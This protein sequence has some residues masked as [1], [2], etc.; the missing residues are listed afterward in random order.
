MG[1]SEITLS[2]DIIGSDE[3]HIAPGDTVDLGARGVLVWL[4]D[5]DAQ[6]YR[7]SHR[8]RAREIRETV[9]FVEKRVR[10]E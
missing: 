8:K 7:L 10:A 2:G 6:A 3:A 4:A 5:E 1:E 9:A